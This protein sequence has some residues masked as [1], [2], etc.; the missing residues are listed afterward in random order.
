[1][2]KLDWV[3]VFRQLVFGCNM[4]HSKERC[5]ASASFFQN[6]SSSIW[7]RWSLELC[8]DAWYTYGFCWCNSCLG[9]FCILSYSTAGVY[10]CFVL[11][12]IRWFLVN[13]MNSIGSLKA[14]VFIS[15]SAPIWPFAI[16]GKWICEYLNESQSWL[17]SNVLADATFNQGVLKLFVI[18]TF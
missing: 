16:S 1:M 15:K 9:C 5:I 13:G 3:I 18:W 7:K 4:I 17:S 8:R 11:T 6:C 12:R 2:Q 10:I 14:K